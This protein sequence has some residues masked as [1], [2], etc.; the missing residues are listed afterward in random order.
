MINFC[1]APGLDI[2]MIVNP[3]DESLHQVIETHKMTFIEQINRYGAILFRGFS[4]YDPESFSSAIA[5]FGLGRRCSTHDYDLA[6]TVL[7]N[8]IYTSSDLPGSIPLPLHHEKPRSIN[9]PNH[10]YFCCV[11][12]PEADGGTIFANAARIWADMPSVIQNE[13]IKHGVLYKQFYHGQSS[14]YLVLK[15]ILGSKWVKNWNEYF[16]TQDKKTIEE[17][18]RRDGV[19]WNWANKG[20]DLVV[21]NHLPG[22]LKHPITEQTLWF[23]SSAYLNYSSNLIY[24][25]LR[26]LRVHHYLASRY[27][28]SKDRFPL[29]CHYG[30][31]QAFS[32]DD[33]VQ[34][35]RILQSHSQVHYW[36][37]GDFMVVDNLTLMHG[38]QPHQGNRLLYSCMTEY[39]R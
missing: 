38:K 24:A 28:M 29:I 8:D 3:N 10:L 35:K 34:I 16:D 5:S 13:L 22:A 19:D 4:C 30:N 31:D 7:A 36:E 6:R 21:L 9:P 33:I 32:A 1:M 14:Q 39:I 17:R 11:T 20:N 26:N 12:P 15:K 18:L 37:R 25:E 23:N 2:P 27:F